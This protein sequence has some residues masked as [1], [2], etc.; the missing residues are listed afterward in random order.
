MR[1]RITSCIDGSPGALAARRA[2]IHFPVAP[3]PEGCRGGLVVMAADRPAVRGH[4]LGH[5]RRVQAEALRDGAVLGG[6][7]II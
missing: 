2:R 6:A 1:A 7:C 5:L 4:V 3:R